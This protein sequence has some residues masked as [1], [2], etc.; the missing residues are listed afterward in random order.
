M[1]KKRD[2]GSELMTAEMQGGDVEVPAYRLRPLFNITREI[3][4]NQIS[5][6]ILGTS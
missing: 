5:H 6:T 1:P 3:S 4:A 2:K